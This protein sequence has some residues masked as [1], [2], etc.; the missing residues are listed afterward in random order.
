LED[1]NV[2]LIKK[3]GGLKYKMFTLIKE[4][5]K[6]LGFWIG[7]A[8]F[9][10]LLISQFV[11][12]DKGVW[13]QIV[14]MIAAVFVAIG[15]FTDTSGEYTPLTKESFM[16]KLN[17]PVLWSSFATLLI[18][19]ITITMGESA[20]TIAN[21]IAGVLMSLFFGVSIYNNPNDREN[22]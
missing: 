1:Q 4:K 20:A 3:L 13:D 15:M 14:G 9:I 10:Y 17:S 16:E 11:A 2:S 8:G 22:L 21:Q 19:V 18:Y 12:I 5:G 6:N 7:L